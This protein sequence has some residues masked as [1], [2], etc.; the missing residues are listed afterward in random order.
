MYLLYKEIFGI[1]RDLE[2]R[3][4]KEGLSETVSEWVDGFRGQDSGIGG[5]ENLHFEN[6]TA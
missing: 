1:K 2:D 4:V 3:G 6:K 5:S